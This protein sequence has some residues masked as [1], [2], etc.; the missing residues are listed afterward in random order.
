ARLVQPRGG[1][2]GTRELILG[3]DGRDGGVLADGRAAASSLELLLAPVGARDHE[4]GGRRHGRGG[5]LHEGPRVDAVRAVAFVQVEKRVKS[6]RVMVARPGAVRGASS[7]SAASPGW[8][9][10]VSVPVWGPCGAAAG[11]EAL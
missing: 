4:R 10:G 3:G 8:A 2:R 6:H 5:R 1:A 11:L 7:S 9:P